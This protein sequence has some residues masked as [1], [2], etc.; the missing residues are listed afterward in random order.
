[1]CAHFFIQKDTKNE[2]KIFVV[3]GVSLS[4]KTGQDV[5]CIKISTNEREGKQMLQKERNNRC[6]E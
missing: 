3:G 4:S 2:F 1:M 6:S 5:E